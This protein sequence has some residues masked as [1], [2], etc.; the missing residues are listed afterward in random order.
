MIFKARKMFP[1]S[2]EDVLPPLA[3]STVISNFMY[4]FDNSYKG[5]TTQ[6]L[7][8][9]IRQHVPKNA[10]DLFDSRVVPMQK[11]VISC[12]HTKALASPS[13]AILKHLLE[14]DSCAQSYTSD[15]FTVIG[16]A[17]TMFKFCVK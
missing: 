8:S 3:T 17:E 16:R 5:H 11:Y 12:T 2:R 13:S 4:C 6:R 14:N 1:N 9:R 7:G 10:G 15:C